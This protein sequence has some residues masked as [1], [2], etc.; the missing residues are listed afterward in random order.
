MLNLGSLC[1]VG[2]VTRTV[3]IYFLEVEELQRKILASLD[4]SLPRCT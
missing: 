1:I 2:M 4:C 3:L